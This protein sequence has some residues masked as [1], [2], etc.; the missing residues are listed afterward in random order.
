MTYLPAGS[1][2]TSWPQFDNVLVTKCRERGLRKSGVIS[3]PKSVARHSLLPSSA[4]PCSPA[5][6]LSPRKMVAGAARPHSVRAIR[7]ETPK[8]PIWGLELMSHASRACGPTHSWLRETMVSRT[9]SRAGTAISSPEMSI[10]CSATNCLRLAG[11][12]MKST[13]SPGLT[14]AHLWV[15]D[16]VITSTMANR[17]NGPCGAVP[18]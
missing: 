16:S 9:A 12:H 15:A 2:A 1:P 17:S 4:L 3:C 5:M 11:R 8:P 18:A 13:S 7:P 14:A 10:V 6:P